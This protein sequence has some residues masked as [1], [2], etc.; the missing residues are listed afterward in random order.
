MKAS[1]TVTVTTV[2]PGPRGGAIFAG[3]DAA[4]KHLRFVAG[5]DRIFRAPVVGEAWSLEGEIRR[6]PH[7]GDQVHVE[8]ASL[9]QPSGRLIIDFLLKYPAFDGLGIGKA[10]AMRLWRNFG[11][12]LNEILSQGDLQKLTAVL[13]EE[14]ARKLVEAWRTVS[15]EATLVS[16]LDKYGFDARLADKVRKIWAGDALTKLQENPYRMLVFAGWEKVD[17]MARSL[18]VPQDDPRRRVAAVEACLY[19]RLD[20]K[21]TLT[22]QVMLLDSVCEALQTRSTGVAQAA[23]ERALSE[24][25]IVAGGGGYQPLGAAVMEKT[26]TNYLHQLLASTPG[27]QRNLFS[28]NLASIM[29][30]AIASFEKSTGLR[31]NA[32][33]RRG[34]T[35]ALYRPLSVLTGGAGT[36]KTTVLQVI[37]RIAEQVT[38]P[39]LQMALS[40][41]AAQHLREATGRPASTIAAFLRAAEQGA[42]NPESEPLAIIDECSMLDLPLMYSI[43]RALPSRAR[44]LLVGDPY[45][46]PPIGF[47]LVFQVLAA[48]LPIPKVVLVEV[49]RQA[50]SS[51]IPQIARGIRYGTVPP[52]PPFVGFG[53]GVNFVEAS[54]GGVVDEI[55]GVLTQ[56]SR[57]NDDAQ[58]LCVTKGGAS[59]T[60]NINATLHAMASATSAKLER[61][62]F[63]EGDPIIYLVNDYQNGLWNGSLGRIENILSSNGRRA[64]LCSLDGAR[65]EIPEEDLHRLDLA[66]AITVHKAQGSQFKRVIVPIVKSRLLDR[67]LIYTALTRGVEQVVFVGDRDA[68]KVAVTTPPRSHERQVGFCI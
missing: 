63:T 28:S 55:L 57:C 44:L 45:Q 61:W 64:L 48:S 19:Q 47:G 58:V 39:V 65:H 56:W 21:H 43:V 34:V 27:P 13:T 35:M 8:Q 38:V 4:G 30:E 53:A 31:L 54:A 40:G 3:R 1:A 14:S 50:Q 26:I 67:T 46:L 15:E 37:H 25:A 49:H 51:G 2:H 42:F 36:G 20:T 62:G 32:E 29:V 5:C 10:K 6:H 17:R 9:T 22:P 68:F 33:Q 18:G 23:V 60:R 59:G 66:Y 52:L 7:Y 16:F 12:D 24:Q 11:S 41:R